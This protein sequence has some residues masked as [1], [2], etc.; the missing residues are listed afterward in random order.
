[1]GLYLD[2]AATT[3]PKPPSVYSA[4]EQA[5]RDIGASPGRGG[6]S[7]SLEAS[8]LL[9]AARESV[10]DLFNCSD[11]SRI[12]FTRNATE[13]L[14][15]AIFGLLRPGSHAITTSMEHNSVARPLYHAEQNG[16]QVTWIQASS[17][18]T[19]TPLQ[20]AGAIRPDTALVV[21]NGCSN[22]TGTLQPV[23]EIGALCRTAGVPFLLDASQMAG[24][25]PL[26]IEALSVDLLAAPGHKGLLGPQGTGVL[27]VGSAIDLQPLLFGGT[28][29][30]STDLA[31]PAE[32]PERLES[33]TPNLPGIAGLAA[34]ITFIRET[35]IASIQEHEMHIVRY[36]SAGLSELPGISLFGPNEGAP[37][38][39]VVSFV[40][41]GFDPSAVG[42]YLDRDYGISVR[43]GLH[44]APLAHRT[45]GTW[46]T[47]TVRVS[48]GF[49]STTADIDQL[50]SALD[51]I[52]KK[53][54]K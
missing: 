18:G 40:L 48:P 53:G 34:G 46:P 20:V 1:M 41:N 31:Q 27:Y 33:G 35:G 9:Y 45:I 16:A 24:I 13:A 51:A 2:N 17:D 23:A 32:L 14:N 7:R 4:V 5:M 52:R 26:D 8:R 38:G 36:L 50:L 10:A 21:V 29:S 25:M 6:Y 43:T 11:P 28:G 54:G 37:R 49:F 44:C 39:S 15:M 30:H 19:V 42:F 47:G 22:V 12:I 3:F